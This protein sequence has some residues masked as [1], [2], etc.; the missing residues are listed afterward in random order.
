MIVRFD[1]DSE[2]RHI[3]TILIEK[4]FLIMQALKSI[5]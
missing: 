5:Y 1:I 3:L 4:L 2:A